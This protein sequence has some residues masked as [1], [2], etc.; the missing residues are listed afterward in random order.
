MLS[1]E[2]KNVI[3]NRLWEYLTSKGFP[4]RS[5]YYYAEQQTYKAWMYNLAVKD[6]DELIEIYIFKESLKGKIETKSSA[7]DSYS[8]D[9]PVNVFWVA[10][11]DNVEPNLEFRLVSSNAVG[12]VTTFQRYLNDLDSLVSGFGNSP[13]TNPSQQFYR[14]Q[15]SIGWS[16]LPPVYR[17]IN[18]QKGINE[19][20]EMFYEAIR[21]CPSDF[22]STMSTFDKLVKMQHYAL[23][24][25]LLNIT[26]NPL[27]ALYFAC[28]NTESK[29]AEILIFDVPKKDV[30]NFEDKDVVV[31]SNIA[32]QPNGFTLSDLQGDV[33]RENP[34][35][36]ISSFQDLQK[37]VCVLPK[38]NNP[39]IS[40]Q[41]GAFFLFGMQQTKAQ[42]ATLNIVPRRIIINTSY[43]KNILQQLSIFGINQS[44]LF[45]E[46]DKVLS[47]IKSK[48]L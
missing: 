31:C 34:Q 40:H 32:K 8:Q 12:S 7:K 15:G 20:R 39:R 44:T 41:Q 21:C 11:N 33:Q 16:L 36:V 4:E 29:Y 18:G 28:Q 35:A 19:E 43:R 48:E 42:C 38:L 14:G 5:L 23:P 9:K 10:L 24:T 6:E 30:L 26:T 3:K 13:D 37:V 27:V 17:K 2:I 45:P 22:P 25:R 1:I 46:L 47:C